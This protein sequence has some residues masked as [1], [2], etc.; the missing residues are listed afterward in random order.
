MP[1][2]RYGAND[3]RIFCLVRWVANIDSES[4]CR[5]ESGTCWLKPAQAI[6]ITFMTCAKIDGAIRIR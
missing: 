2:V 1:L 3:V 5:S 6:R 4:T